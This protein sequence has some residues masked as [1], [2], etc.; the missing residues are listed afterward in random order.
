MC[1]SYDKLGFFFSLSFFNGDFAQTFI[2]NN[3]AIQAK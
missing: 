3:R 2:M 1:M